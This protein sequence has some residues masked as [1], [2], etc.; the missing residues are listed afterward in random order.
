M[1]IQFH[2]AQRKKAKLRLAVAGP[3]GSGKTYSALQVSFGLGGRVVLIDT[4]RGSGEL[5]AHLGEYD[6][7]TLTAP[8]TPEKYVEAI[9]AAE[10]AGYD[11]IIIDSLSHAWAGPGG[12]L[13]IHGYAADKGGNSW[14][15]WRQVTPRH[16]ELV[17][18][19]LQSRCHIIATLRSKMEHVQV[20]ENGKTVVKKV[21]LNPIQ[22]DG[23]EYEFTVFLDLDYNHTASATKDRTGLFDGLVFKPGA[24]TGTRLLEWLETGVEVQSR[25]GRQPN[26][27]V[28]GGGQAEAGSA[29]GGTAGGAGE[30]RTWP[31]PEA[32]TGGGNSMRHGPGEAVNPPAPERAA[33]DRKQQ[34]AGRAGRLQ[35]SGGNHTH[36]T[37]PAGPDQTA[38]QSRA[39]SQTPAT[40]A[41]LKKIFATA[42]E[43]GLDETALHQLIE[44]ETGKQ[45]ARD[46]AKPEA[47]R[48][49]EL[50]LSVAGGRPNPK[51]ESA[52]LPPRA[53]NGGR[54]RLF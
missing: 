6:V 40:Q 12:V 28:V 26:L 50:L 39:A 4:E 8:F 34:A 48:V 32:D 45:S 3:A 31:A 54:M 22:R 18:A 29:A 37:A 5:Y 24:E 23:L 43:A 30:N 19:M 15:A 51:P 36:S 9:R 33:F 44:Q 41:Q 7:C 27:T 11:V 21:G 53:A 1:S 42:G 46:L 49:I 10:N 14:S 16:N 38:R 25:A 17:D 35:N 13:D 20:V 2:P 52:P 47:S